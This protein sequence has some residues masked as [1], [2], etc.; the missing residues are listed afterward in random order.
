MSSLRI[1][2]FQK[3][4][5][6]ITCRGGLLCKGTFRHDNWRIDLVIGL[7]FNDHVLAIMCLQQKIG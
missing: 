2:G 3:E 1:A 5:G 6:H 7:H 4:I